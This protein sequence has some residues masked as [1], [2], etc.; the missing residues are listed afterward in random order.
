MDL[1]NSVHIVWAL[2]H[3]QQSDLELK[4]L[5]LLQNSELNLRTYLF[6]HD[7]VYKSF[8]CCFGRNIKGCWWEE[9]ENEIIFGD[10]KVF[11][12]D[13][14]NKNSYSIIIIFVLSYFLCFI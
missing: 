5:E 11:Y 10:T 1:L 9:D 6:F 12:A 3:L 4:V 7:I 13:D 14:K 8:S 2:N